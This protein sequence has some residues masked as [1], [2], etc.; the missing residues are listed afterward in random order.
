MLNVLL[1]QIKNESKTTRRVLEAIPAGK[2]D[3]KPD[4]KAKTALELAWHIAHSEVWF[5]DAVENGEFNADAGAMPEDIKTP[6]DIVAWYDTNFAASFD[7]VSNLSPD[8]LV[9]PINFYNVFTNPAI[10]YL[11]FLIVHSVHHR[12]Q[13]STYLRPMGSK[14]PSIYGGSADEPFEMPTQAASA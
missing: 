7:R 12:G 5:L 6:A 1:P 2:S 4:P 3:Y 11:N 8:K 13:L 14:V 9:K 10:L